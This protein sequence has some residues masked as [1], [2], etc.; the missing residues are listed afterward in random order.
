M[1]VLQFLT[2]GKLTAYSAT[3]AVII[4]QAKKNKF[5]DPNT[6]QKNIDR[7]GRDFYF[8]FLLIFLFFNS[9]DSLELD[10]FDKRLPCCNCLNM[11]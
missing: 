11:L 8:I 4:D 1:I 3:D 6:S 10:G 9:Q 2:F 7:V 5:L